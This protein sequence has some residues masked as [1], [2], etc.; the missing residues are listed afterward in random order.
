M[1][2]SNINPINF[3]LDVILIIA[4]IWMVM[5]VRGLGGII[6]RGLNLITIG[7]VILGFAHLISTLDRALFSLDASTDAIVHRVI[8]LIGFLVLV[9]GFR[10]INAINK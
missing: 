4:A 6:G 5:T 7:A 9:I 3:T 10:Q 1:M 8:V 2:F